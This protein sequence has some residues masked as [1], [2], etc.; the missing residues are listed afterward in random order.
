MNVWSAADWG[1][2]GGVCVEA[3]ALYS[4]IRNSERW[5]WRRPIPQGLMAYVVSVVLRAG[6]GAVLAAAGAGNGQISGTFAAFG[7]GVAAPLVV[8]KLSHAIPLTGT[9]NVD[10]PGELEEAHTTLA[11]H[12][13]LKAANP[14]G[15][16]IGGA[17]DAR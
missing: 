5:S 11:E 1:L 13:P 3:L 8:E 14:I 9:L 15:A 4:L 17:G 10:S 12:L 2:A 16:D 6:A 7:L